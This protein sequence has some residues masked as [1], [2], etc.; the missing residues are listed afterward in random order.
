[1]KIAAL[2]FD[3]ITV[4]DIVGPIEVLSWV[5]GSEIIWVGKENGPIRAAPTGLALIVERTL[6][7]V[8]GADILIIRTDEIFAEHSSFCWPDLRR[9]AHRRPHR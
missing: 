7:E 1:M 4:L 5:P 6:D 3:K 9:A 8:S 2:I